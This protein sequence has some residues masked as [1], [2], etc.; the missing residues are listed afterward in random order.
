MH[1]K[2]NYERAIKPNN[3]L[4]LPK[5]VDV[6]GAEHTNQVVGVSSPSIWEYSISERER[7]GGKE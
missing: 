1:G 4:A 6:I 2:V 3:N 5:C 7:N